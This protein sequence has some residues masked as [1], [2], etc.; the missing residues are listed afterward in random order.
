LASDPQLQ[1][2]PYFV[3]VDH[4]RFGN[5]GVRGF[6][7]EFSKTPC[8]ISNLVLELGQH[9]EEILTEELGYTWD[10][11]TLLKDARVIL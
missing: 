7:V 10:Q 5:V 8:S 4:P 9:T 1:E 6:P 11:V 3:D 2:N